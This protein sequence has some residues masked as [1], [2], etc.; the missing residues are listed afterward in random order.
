MIVQN[1]LKNSQ[2]LSNLAQPPNRS[3]A[4][5]QSLVAPTQLPLIASGTNQQRTSLKS[6]RLPQSSSISTQP[7]TPM[8]H[9]TTDS[10]F[11]FGHTKSA[12]KNPVRSSFGAPIQSS[13]SG[14]LNQQ[15]SRK[16]SEKMERSTGK[17]E[18]EDMEALEDF[19]ESPAIAM[20]G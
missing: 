11:A 6:P 1:K 2:S 16:Q 5:F 13:N 9:Q 4:V 3:A 19:E 12:T 8:M 18:M 14:L 10:L 7:I 20:L 17:L 15:R